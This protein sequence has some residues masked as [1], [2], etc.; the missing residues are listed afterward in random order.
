M[1]LFW[2]ESLG[3][4]VTVATYDRQLWDVSKVAGLSV[5]PEGLP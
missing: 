2:Q 5:W 4:E 1:A 3:E